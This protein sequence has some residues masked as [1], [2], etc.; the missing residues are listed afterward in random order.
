[1][2]NFPTLLKHFRE[3]ACLSQSKLAD[4]SGF[5]HSYISRL[6]SNAR[7][8]TRDAVVKL[9]DALKLD[10]A[11]WQALMIAAGFI[12]DDDGELLTALKEDLEVSGLAAVLVDARLSDRYRT[13]VR[14]QVQVLIQQAEIVRGAA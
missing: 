7:T 4:K 9:S 14:R 11:D 6:E 5:D 10:D 2:T 1:M 3:R 8:P 12:S 13:S